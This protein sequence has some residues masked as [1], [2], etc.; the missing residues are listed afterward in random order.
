MK[1]AAR[2]VWDLM[3][4]GQD[5]VS[6]DEVEKNVVD[7][8]LDEEKDTADDDIPDAACFAARSLLALTTQIA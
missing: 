5:N 7:T 4:N 1:E 3:D 6:V 2:K 8:A